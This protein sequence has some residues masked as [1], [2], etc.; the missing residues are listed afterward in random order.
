MAVDN[1]TKKFVFEHNEWELK[2]NKS[3]NNNQISV[4]LV[5]NNSETIIPVIPIYGNIAQKI[6]IIKSYRFLNTDLRVKRTIGIYSGAVDNTIKDL[7]SINGIDLTKH[8]EIIG[9]QEKIIMV[10]KVYNS[11]LVIDNLDSSRNEKII[12][13]SKRSRTNIVMSMLESLETNGDMNITKI[14]YACNLN[15]QYCSSIIEDLIRNKFIEVSENSNSII[16]YRLTDLGTK[17]LKK[18]RDINDNNL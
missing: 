2:F 18:L 8:I 15:Y 12:K 9:P 4:C 3:L 16:K 5:S 11:S 6:S 14:V 7:A 13:K 17:Y 1:N 10:L